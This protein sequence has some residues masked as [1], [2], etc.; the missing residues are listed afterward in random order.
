MLNSILLYFIKYK[1]Q[2]GNK[3]GFAVKILPP[4]S[5]NNK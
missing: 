5:I 3:S 2:S 1:Y 4:A